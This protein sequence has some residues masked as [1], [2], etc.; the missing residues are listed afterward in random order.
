MNRAKAVRILI[1]NALLSGTLYIIPGATEYISFV[2]RNENSIV[3]LLLVCALPIGIA[4]LL[5]YVFALVISLM[6]GMLF[7]TLF[8][9][10]FVDTNNP[11]V[12]SFYAP[13]SAYGDFYM[14]LFLMW[15]IALGT[16]AVLRLV[17]RYT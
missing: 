15:G 7:T 2:V 9:Q 12:Y 13:G 6:S 10:F 11:L 3:P 1:V 8:V 4:V 17:A 14:T 5:P 16:H